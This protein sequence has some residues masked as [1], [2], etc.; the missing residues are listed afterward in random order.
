MNTSW[1]KVE[2]SEAADSKRVYLQN[3][4]HVKTIMDAPVIF[5]VQAEPWIKTQFYNPHVTNNSS[6]DA[7]PCSRWRRVT[8]GTCA[9]RPSSPNHR[10]SPG[11][12]LTLIR[13]AGSHSV[14]SVWRDL[15]TPATY[16]MVVSHSR[17]RP[18]GNR[19][20]GTV[21]MCAVS[22]RKSVTCETV[23][24]RNLCLLSHGSTARLC[25]LGQIHLPP[26]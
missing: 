19:L 7:C 13:R 3:K 9:L 25:D 1:E 16:T 26:D 2:R 17:A 18:A 14:R 23:F 11:Q 10:R 22:L 20:Q 15:C 8:I 4:W 5:N 12:T 6:Q 24:E 21:H